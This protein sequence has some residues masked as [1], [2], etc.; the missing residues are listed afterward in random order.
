MGWNH[1]GQC[2]GLILCLSRLKLITVE[3]REGCLSEVERLY[4]LGV[5]NREIRTIRATLTAMQAQVHD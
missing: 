2:I 1:L 5:E 4:A 3:Q